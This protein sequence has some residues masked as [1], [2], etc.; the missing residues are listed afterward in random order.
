MALN[1]PESESN[2][3]TSEADVTAEFEQP[4]TEVEESSNQVE[5]E[6]S[7]TPEPD[8]TKQV[9]EDVLESNPETLSEKPSLANTELENPKEPTVA[10]ESD[11]AETLNQE[12]KPVLVISAKEDEKTGKSQVTRPLGS[13]KPKKDPSATH[14]DDSSSNTSTPLLEKKETAKLSFLATITSSD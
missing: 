12:I 8:D 11:V 9:K 13:P 2:N 4:G 7:S 5:Q 10:Q 14:Q 1:N 3:Q 6:K